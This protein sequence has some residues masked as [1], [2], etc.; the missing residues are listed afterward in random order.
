MESRVERRSVEAVEGQARQ[1]LRQATA[2][3]DSLDVQAAPGNP[4]TEAA[5][6]ETLRDLDTGVS[7]LRRCWA[8]VRVGRTGSRNAP[9][10]AQRLWTNSAREGMRWRREQGD[11]GRR[12]PMP[13]VRIL[14]P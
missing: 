6:P 13:K 4:T 7:R 1:S 14:H 2:A 5:S 8:A 3:A 12:Q 9:A 10:G 11:S